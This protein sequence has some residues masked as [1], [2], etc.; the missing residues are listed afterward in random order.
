MILMKMQ[1][2]GGRGDLQYLPDI[3]KKKIAIIAGK[4]NNGEMGL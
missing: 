1:E 2:G 3:H 4:G